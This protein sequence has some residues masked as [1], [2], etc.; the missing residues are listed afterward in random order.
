M[1]VGYEGYRPLATRERAVVCDMLLDEREDNARD[2][3][4]IEHM[5]AFYDCSII[6]NL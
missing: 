5:F 1:S 2:I 6:F 3:D 4:R